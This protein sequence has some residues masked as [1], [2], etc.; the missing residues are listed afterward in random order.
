M[1]SRS[2]VASCFRKHRSIGLC[3]I[4]RELFD[5][6]G[7]A[8]GAHRAIGATSR[9]RQGTGDEALADAA[10]SG[11]QH[12]ELV[13]DPGERIEQRDE[14]GN[15]ATRGPYVETLGC[16][17]LRQ[18][19]PAQTL[20]KALGV[21]VGDLVLDVEAQ[22]LFEGAGCAWSAATPRQRPCRA[23]AAGEVVGSSVRSTRSFP[24]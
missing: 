15:D 13:L 1:Y 16:G 2:I 20:C 23:V 10:G 6:P 3:V 8:I 9:V 12:V 19:R 11:D 7:Q 17:M 21:A 5:E 18:F 4:T 14:L 24:F 22:P